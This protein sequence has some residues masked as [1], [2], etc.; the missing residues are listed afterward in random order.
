MSKKSKCQQLLEK[1]VNAA[2]SSIEIYNKPDFKYREESFSILMVNAWELLLKAKILKDNNNKI[3]SLYAIDDSKSKNKDGLPKKKAVYKKNRAGNYWTIDIRYALNKLIL[4]KILK[5]NIELLVEIRDN[6]IHFYNKSKSLEKKILEVGT[7]S[8][9][10]YTT[11]V[12]EWFN[13]DLSQYNFFLMPISFF[14][15]TE[16]SPLVFAAES[17]QQKNLLSHI[18]EI[19][20]LYPTEET[21]SHSI[22]LVLK[23]KFVRSNEDSPMLVKYDPSN[24]DAISIKIDE[25]QNFNNKYPWAYTLD[26]L[27]KLKERYVDFRQAAPFQKLIKKLQKDSKYCGFRYLDPKRRSGQPQKFYSPRILEEF[28]RLFKKK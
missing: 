20:K 11:T 19:E 12:N 25:E 4:D 16:V 27:P 1:S 10:S 22:S 8:L 2:I 26:L 14:N 17:P 15:P 13:Y 21:S 18:T 24:P 28:D 9:R 3:N 7:A 23:T 6:A 5:E